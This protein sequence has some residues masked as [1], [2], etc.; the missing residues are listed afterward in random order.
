[1]LA[2]SDADVRCVRPAVRTGAVLVP[3]STLLRPPELLAQAT[4]ASVTHLV[5][6]PE[7]R[8]RTSSF[9]IL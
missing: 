5:V 7:F 6:V 1:M 9:L 2:K 3:L 4:T 8:T